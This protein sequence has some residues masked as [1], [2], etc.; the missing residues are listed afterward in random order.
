M[1]ANHRRSGS[2]AAP[3]GPRFLLGLACLLL[4]TGAAK[5]ADAPANRGG[6]IDWDR[7]RALYQRE[8]RGERLSPE[9]QAYLDRAKAERQRRGARGPND[10]AAGQV[11]APKDSTGL[12]PL[13]QMKGGEKYKG[14]EGGLYGGGRNEP[15]EAQAKAAAAA[16]AQIAPLDANGKPSADGRVV[17]LALGMSNT[18]QEFS[19]FKQIADADP[20]KSPKL[21]IVDG[22][23]GGKDAA[24]WT[25]VDDKGT[26]GVWEEADRRL[27]AAGVTPRQVQA[28][29]IKQALI[30]QGRHGEFPAHAKVLQKEL[31]S[32]LRLAKARYPN[33]RLAY[34]SSRIYAGYASTPLNPEPY[35]YE[36]AFAVRRVI[37]DQVN[38]EPGLNHDPAKGEVKAPV[39]L[40]GPYLWADGVKGRAG[41]D[42]VYRRE[43]LAGDGTHPSPSGRQ[44]VAELLLKFFKTDPT[45]KVWFLSG[46]DGKDGR[47]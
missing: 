30:Q 23:Q 8:Q 35:A 18:T 12:V 44:K 9:E 39:A 1:N 32:T 16:A 37:E 36:G 31:E 34:L 2:A 19:R 4:L 6:D 40:W 43:D 22:A 45:A 41:D 27:K 47:R 20:D 21:V 17:L 29:W 38:G 46:N 7:G 42:L 33:L 14:F 28:V 5:A 13:T 25:N 11:P 10:A 26:N 3:P 24:A 15:P